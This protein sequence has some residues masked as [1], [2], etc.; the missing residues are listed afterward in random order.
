MFNIL[1]CEDDLHIL[2]L[3]KIRLTQQGYK[4]YTATNGEEGLEIFEN[5]PIDLMIVDVTMP[6]MNGF[7]LVKKVRAL[8]S[9]VPAIIVSARGNLADKTQGFLVGIDDYMVK[10]IEFGELLLRI[11]ALMRRA[12]IVIEQK[13]TISNV[14]LDYS[15]L[16]V[17]D[18]AER[19]VVLTKREFSILFK[20]LS[21]PERAFTKGQL[22]DEFWGFGSASSEDT[23]KVFIN[24]IRSKIK[25]FPEIDIA[26]IR[27]IGYKGI[28]NEK[29]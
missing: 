21:Y 19:K 7:E 20:L 18:N 10:P 23:V 22:F 27:G 6:K 5:N 1:I 14:V 8:D 16:S 9:Q 3:M 15:S 11:K 13:I 25:D 2:Q 12:K 24:R 28:R 29:N 17:S 26:T 4:T